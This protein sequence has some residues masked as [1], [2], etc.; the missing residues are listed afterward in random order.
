MA[1]T[2]RPKQISVRITDREN[3]DMRHAAE[4]D[5]LPF[6]DWVRRRLGSAASLTLDANP[7][8]LTSLRPSDQA[9]APQRRRRPFNR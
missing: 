2:H 1:D 5:G 4:L 6:T 9:R 7:P 8:V 3:E